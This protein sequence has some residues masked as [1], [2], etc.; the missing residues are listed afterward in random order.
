MANP[1]KPITEKIAD[2]VWRHAG[3]LRQGMNVYSANPSPD[4]EGQYLDGDTCFF[5]VHPQ[6]M[7]TLPHDQYLKKT[8]S[9]ALESRQIEITP[10]SSTRY[11]TS[12]RSTAP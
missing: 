4:I 5:C 11:R 2:R 10:T 8:R 7:E 3:D 6:L 9:Q 12:A 1:L